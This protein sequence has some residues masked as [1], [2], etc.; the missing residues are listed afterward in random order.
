MYSRS[1]LTLFV[2]LFLAAVP[3]GADEKHAKRPITL[4]DIWKVKRLGKP[5]LSPDGKWA[6]VDVTSFSMDDNTSTTQ[7][8]A[9]STDGKIQKQLTAGKGGSG[10]VWSP[11]GKSIAFTSRRDGDLAQIY[12]ISPDGGEARQL[13]KLPMAA[14]G[15]KWS[16]DAETVYCVVWTW[17]D[18]HDDESYRKKEKAKKDDKVQA[19]VIDD[20]L[21]RVWDKWIADGKRP[22]VFAVDAET[23][24]YKNLFAHTK[25]TL[26]ASGGKAEDYDVSPDGKEICFTSESAK[27]LGMDFN[28]DLYTM[29]LEKRF[30]QIQR[31]LKEQHTRKIGQKEITYEVTRRVSG[32]YLD[33]TGTGHVDPGPGRTF[34]EGAVAIVLANGEPKNITADNPANDFAPVYS[35]DGKKIAFSRQTTKFFY[36]DRTRIMVHDRASGQNTEITGALDRSCGS[37]Q[38]HSMWDPKGGFLF[39][40]AEDKGY[41]RLYMSAP[42]SGFKPRPFSK[43]SGYTDLSPTLSKDGDTTQMAFL[44]SQFEVPPALHVMNVTD[45]APTPIR[46]DKFNDDLRVQWDLGKVKE[47]TFKGADDEDVQMWIVYP[48]HFDPKKKWP[49]LQIVHGGPHGA[50]TNDFSFRWNLHLF[51]SKGY[52]VAAVNFHGSSGFGQ[53]FCDS[54]TGDMASKPFIDVMKGTDYM[55]KEPYIDKE[56]MV[57]AGGSYGGFMMAWL[58]GHTDRFKAMV[59]HA[60]AYNWHSMMASDFVRD[61]ERRLGALPFGDQARIDKQNAQ[62]FA[63][64]FKTPTLILHGEKDF[65]VPVTQGFEYYNT[66]RQKGVPT[67]L[68]YF[69][70]ENHWILRPQNS[71]LW[72]LEFFAWLEK[73]VGSG[74]TANQ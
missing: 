43:S 3:T 32:A 8:W 68:V 39:F 70:D 56:R 6:A 54:I 64:N 1:G 21:F 24:K 73:Y 61:R 37:V 58:N 15:L 72:H 48:P 63:P 14:S 9:L 29:S 4:E 20:A 62:R 41:H 35:P 25:R 18:T 13:S 51:A 10:A 22:V 52:V 55:E 36:A 2:C 17:P 27:E 65:R 26:P 23:G 30:H 16:R 11:D 59:C 44:R 42:E 31:E 66:L 49:L 53:K 7:V 47:V 57:C 34:A 12:L 5:S 50:I 67:R 45:K 33:D 69:P 60:G 19:F 74:P 71:R 28:L 46:V 40:E 38:W